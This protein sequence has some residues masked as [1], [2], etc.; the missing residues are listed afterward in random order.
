MNVR[1]L[2]RSSITLIV[3]VFYSGQG[4]ADAW[5]QSVSARI[6]TEYDTNPTMTQTNTDG[7]WRTLFE[8]SYT[9]T[10]IFKE[11]EVKTGFALQTVRSSN[12]TLSPSRDSPTA[13]LDWLHHMEQGEFEISSKYAEIATRDAGID[14]SGLV[15]VA[16]T[17]TSRT[18]S[19]RFSKSLNERSI[20]SADGS[21][22]SVSYKGGAYVDYD[23]R[24][25]NMLINYTWSE[26]STPFLKTSYADYVPT[27]GGPISRFASAILGLNWQ[28]SDSLAGTLH[29]GKYKITGIAKLG[30]LGGAGLQYTGELNQLSLNAVRQVL[31]TGLGG[32]VIVDQADGNWSYAWSER[33][34]VGID[35]VWRKT[36]FSPESINRTA[37]AWLQQE[38][39]SFWTVRGYCMRNT[40]NGGVVDGASSSILGISFVY[41]NTDF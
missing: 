36:Y 10:R 21:Y 30:T 40:L 17:R 4:R 16:S 33:S 20:L 2:A 11:D 35:L 31:P 39:N 41:T 19:G 26:R 7:V 23:T 12:N 3:L 5:Q 13:L 28:F 9:L 22:E 38:L 8:P 1:R 25:A 14:A 34:K 6:S 37:G 29:A 24:S 18:T 15:P 27:N 32:F